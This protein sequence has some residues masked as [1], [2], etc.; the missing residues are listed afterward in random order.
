MMDDCQHVWS[1]DDCC[2][3]CIRCGIGKDTADTETIIAELTSENERLRE[4]LARL[5]EEADRVGLANRDPSIEHSY[6]ALEFAV[7]LA[8]AILE[9]DR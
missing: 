3:Y 2:Q 8:R 6:A 1:D 9:R 4:A 5:V 7:V